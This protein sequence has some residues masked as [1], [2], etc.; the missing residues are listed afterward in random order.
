MCLFLLPKNNKYNKRILFM[1]IFRGKNFVSAVSDYKDSVRVATR[2]NVNLSGSVLTVDGVSLSDK[3][4]VLLLGQTT[5]SQNGIYTWSVSTSQLTRA[6]DADGIFE[7]SAGNKIYVEEGN[8]HAKSTWTLITQGVITPGTTSLVFAKE[9]R[10]N[11][12]DVSGNYG[13]SGKTLQL[14][15]DETGT[16]DSIT[17]VDIELDGGSF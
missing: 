3:D 5:A 9:G 13:G 10:I 8:S 14:S 4:R 16:I 15:L 11:A 17:A 6:N 7:L 12:T 2:S 1:P